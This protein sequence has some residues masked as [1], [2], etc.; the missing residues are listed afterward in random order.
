MMHRLRSRRVREAGPAARAVLFLCAVA[1][2]AVAGTAV[3]AAER[4]LALSDPWMRVV[5][6]SRPAAGYFILSNEAGKAESL[7]GASSSACGMLMLHQSL[8]Q[9]GVERMVMV[10]SISVP[11]HGK[12]EFTPGGYHLMCMSPTKDV[13]PG[14]SVPVT[15]RFA[16]GGTLTVPFPVRGAT[17]K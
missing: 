1:A 11:A 10:K 8:H 14:R 3:A 2:V 16:D 6:P 12:V 17:G 5:M 9:S 13:T 7:V 15:L 4:G